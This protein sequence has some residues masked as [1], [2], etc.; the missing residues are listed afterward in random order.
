MQLRRAK[1]TPLLLPLAALSFITLTGCQP[2]AP[3]VTDASLTQAVQ[4]QLAADHALIGIPL[5]TV[6]ASSVVTLSG[7]VSNDAQRTIAARDAAGIA[8]VRQVINNIYLAP[9]ITQQAAIAAP[10]LPLPRRTAPSTPPPPPPA[11]RTNT[12]RRTPAPVERQDAPPAR[13][14]QTYQASASQPQPAPVITP[15]TFRTLTVPSGNALP[16]RITQTLDSATT[17]TDSTFSG[18][19]ASDVVID[20]IV[21][22]PAGSP[23]T[24]HVDAVQEAAH[25]KGS[26][27]LTVSLTGLT[28]RGDRN[29][30]LS[31]EP[32]TVEGKG[33]GKNTAVKTGGGA[34]VGALLGGIFGGG[35]GAAIGAAAGGGVGAGSNA[36]TR[37]EQV[38]IPSESV[39]RFR[40][41]SPVTV[42]V[43][44]DGSSPQGSPD[45]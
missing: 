10:A 14:Q 8:G 37:G 19:L 43:R 23:V 36:I 24:G 12:A 29:L 16:V 28:R 6:V 25:F 35:K 3:P 13:Q 4:A 32:Y 15:P 41:A 11:V 26:S 45:T 34:A 27:L 7:T 33:R 39:V 18:V 1:L 9:P 22:M 38:Q 44:T 31:T 20:G 40:L 30:A 17:Q 2:G 21:A 5:Q 42:R